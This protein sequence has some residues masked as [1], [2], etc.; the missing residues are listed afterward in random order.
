LAE[1]IG[2]ERLLTLHHLHPI[3]T[4]LI[5]ELFC[6][7]NDNPS[8]GQLI[9]VNHLTNLLNL[10]LRRDQIL[11]VSK[12][13]RSGTK[14]KTLHQLGA[15]SDVSFE[16]EYLRGDYGAIPNTKMSQYNLFE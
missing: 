7:E 3:L 16:K 8:G 12:E 9:F 5:V 14:V 2:S 10:H 15:R 1:L 11:L 13:K 4:A 6:S